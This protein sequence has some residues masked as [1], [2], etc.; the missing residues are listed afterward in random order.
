MNLRYFLFLNLHEQ[1]TVKVSSPSNIN[2]GHTSFISIT[3]LPIKFFKDI[4][5]TI[6]ITELLRK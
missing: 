4:L 3:F 1:S 5:F 2:V 6:G